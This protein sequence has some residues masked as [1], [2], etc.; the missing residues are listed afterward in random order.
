V[1][2]AALNLRPSLAFRNN[3]SRGGGKPREIT[4]GQA[5]KQKGRGGILLDLGTQDLR[6]RGGPPEPL[7]SWPNE[8][9]APPTAAAQPA[10]AAASAAF[11][12]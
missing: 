2:G 4:A 1:A 3:N 7:Q 12:L 9:T 5:E 10:S 8:T 6:E 11:P